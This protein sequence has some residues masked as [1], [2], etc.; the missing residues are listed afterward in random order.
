MSERIRFHLDENANLAIARGLRQ[1]GI[2]ITTTSEVGL[3]GQ[4]DEIQFD[5][6][7]TQ[8]RAMITHDA[9]FLRFASQR[10]DHAGIAF[11]QKETRSIG[12]IIR[13]LVLLYEI[14]TP[15]EMNGRVEY[16]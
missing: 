11:C 15:E 1:Q 13:G 8:K 2:D 4:P 6:V 3:L 12:E 10:T 9:D 5:H 16:L 14:Y 7:R